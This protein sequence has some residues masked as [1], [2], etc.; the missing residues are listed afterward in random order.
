VLLPPPSLLP[1]ALPANQLPA[2]RHPSLLPLPA[3]GNNDEKQQ[4]MQWVLQWMRS[5]RAVLT[6][7]HMVGP[8]KI[9]PSAGQA[10]ML[11][12]VAGHTLVLHPETAAIRVHD[13][14][15]RL[16]EQLIGTAGLAI[17]R[18]RQVNVCSSHTAACTGPCIRGCTE[19]QNQ[20]KET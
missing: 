12:L 7:F 5:W 6:H 13:S 3:A 19:M 4:N 2:D 16:E 14:H 20:P 18:A 8:N 10:Q 17:A 9:S 1:A 11:L 15:L